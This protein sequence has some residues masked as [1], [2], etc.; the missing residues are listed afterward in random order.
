MKVRVEI[1][2]KDTGIIFG[3]IVEL[4]TN[5]PEDMS[6]LRILINSIRSSWY[7]AIIPL[8]LIMAILFGG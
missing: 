8:G 3:D 1:R 2:E 7:L 6:F 4:D 5:D